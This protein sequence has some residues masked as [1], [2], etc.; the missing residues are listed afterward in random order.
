MVPYNV[1]TA[2]SSSK[3]AY[4]NQIYLITID[5]VQNTVILIRM[6]PYNDRSSEKYAYSYQKQGLITID[7][8]YFDQKIRYN[9]RSS[10]KYGYSDQNSTL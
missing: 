4:C 8:V 5:Q 1:I 9:D 6:V 7:R 10:P 3:I 2:R